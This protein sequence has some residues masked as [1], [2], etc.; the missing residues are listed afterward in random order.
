VT[1]DTGAEISALIEVLHATDH[2]LEELLAGEVD[3]VTDKEG[4]TILLRRAQGH[5]RES[6]NARQ[7]AILNGLPANIALLDA[8]G[9]IVSVNTAWRQFANEGIVHAPGHALGI[10]YPDICGKVGESNFFEA[11]QV[12]T[13]IRS[14]LSGATAN[15]SLEYPCHSAT[16]KRWL[17]LRVTPLALHA[18]NGAIVMHVDITERRLAAEALADL[19]R[20]TERRERM[21]STMLSSISD[22]AYIYDRQGRFLFANKPMLD[23]WGISLDQAVGKNYF[24]LGYSADVALQLQ[25]QVQQVFELGKSVTFETS[26]TS[27]SDMEGFYEY[28]YSPA[29][30]DDGSLDFVV[31]ITRDITERKRNQTALRELNADLESRVSVRTSELARQEALFH[32][33]ADQAPAIIWTLDAAAT[34]FTYMNRAGAQLL[35]GSEAG[36]L[37]QSALSAV[38]PEDMEAT[39]LEKNRALQTSS[40]F[41]SVRRLRAADGKFRIMS[42]RASPVLDPNGAVDFWVGIEID[43]TEIK[44]AGDDLRLSNSE[45]ESFA[46]AIA[47]DL[48]SPLTLINAFGRLLGKEMGASMTN[49]ATHLLSRMLAGVKQ[50]DEVSAGLLALAVVSRKSIKLQKTDLSQ[51]AHE[52]AELLSERS[53]ERKINLEIQRDMAALCDARMLRSLISNLIENAWKFTSKVEHA[54]ISFYSSSGATSSNGPGDTIYYMCD[55]GAGFDM[56]YADKLFAPFQRLHSIE[57]FEGTGIGLATVRKIAERHGGWIRASGHPGKGATIEFTL[58]AQHS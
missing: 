54:E 28:V 2:R 11:G 35:G 31:G 58:G 9:V 36:W 13:G 6:E 30:A 18:L 52:V 32:A 49:R 15:F 26:N 42:C 40:T 3:S 47:H 20:R 43:I 41:I 5:L 25:H 50:M 14:V 34:R 16:E 53:P 21:L 27:R 51:I 38:H 29:F 17:M 44:Q 45:L 10:N 33:L 7:A 8:R 23:L 39:V 22:F 12:A 57:E 37:G 4:R 19:S 1:P 48:R 55:N 56:T 24:D 46:Y